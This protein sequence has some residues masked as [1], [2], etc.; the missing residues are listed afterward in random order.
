MRIL[1]V[2]S[3]AVLLYGRCV[4]LACQVRLRGGDEELDRA[5]R[6]I[7][8]FQAENWTMETPVALDDEVR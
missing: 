4:R 6:L 7:R 8:E 2:R 5:E 3:T 1:F